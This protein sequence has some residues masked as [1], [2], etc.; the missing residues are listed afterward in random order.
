MKQVSVRIHRIDTQTAYASCHIHGPE[1]IIERNETRVF[2]IGKHPAQVIVAYVQIMII[3]VGCN[4]IRNRHP[5]HVRAYARKEIVVDFIQVVVLVRVQM[6]FE[7]HA[8]GQETRMDADVAR[9]VDR[10]RKEAQAG[11]NDEQ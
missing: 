11:G 8:V 6:Q 5:R 7:S 2:R 1:K 10:R 4:G 9:P 3:K